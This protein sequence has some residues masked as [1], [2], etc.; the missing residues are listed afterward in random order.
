MKTVRVF[1]SVSG[2][3]ALGSTDH[4]AREP[5]ALTRSDCLDVPSRRFGSW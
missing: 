4:V 2:E 5:P 1:L 3:R